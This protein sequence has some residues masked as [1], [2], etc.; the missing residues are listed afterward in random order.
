MCLGE[1]ARNANKAARKNYEHQLK[2]REANWMEQRG[3]IQLDRIQ[4]EQTLQAGHVGL[5]NAYAEIQEKYRDLIGQAMQE[6]EADWVKFNQQNVGASMAAAG[7]TG[8]S[9]ERIRAVEL[10]QYLKQASRRA[11]N[12]QHAKRDLDREGAMAAA[13]KRQSDMQSFAHNNV[14]RSPELAPPKPV[15]HNVGRAAWMDAMKMGSAALGTATSVAVIASSRELKDNLKKLGQSKAGHNIYKFNYKGDSRKYIGV[16]AEEV[17][18]IK[19]E[20]V[21]TLPNGKL[22]VKYDLIDVDFKEVP[23]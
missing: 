14:V 10:G 6:N 23:A 17:Q 13:Q 21:T 8:R 18:Q 20:A 7:Q 5:G 4:H 19:P 15:M 11:Y 1:D 16:V 12:L 22:G 3:L 2:V 9:A